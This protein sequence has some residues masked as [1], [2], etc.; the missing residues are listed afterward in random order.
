MEVEVKQLSTLEDINDMAGASYDREVKMGLRKWLAS[1][2]TPLRAMMFKL[3]LNG[4]KS[5][6]ATHFVRHGI[7]TIWA[8]ES[9]RTDLQKK[10]RETLKTIERETPVL[11]KGQVNAQ[12]L[13]NIS[14]RR[15]CLNSHKDT[16]KAWKQVKEAVAEV[17]PV[18]AQFMVVEC[19][20][21]NGLCGEPKCCGYNKTA[22]FR[23]EL[24]EYKKN[25]NEAPTDSIGDDS[26]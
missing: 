15:L 6:I 3:R 23:R 2:H 5:F 21:R 16:V 18:V 22:K 11:M 24:A 26:I 13:I 20:Y 4:I 12:A 14:R 10:M 1:E 25:F 19:V 9:G 7:G 8:I 17:E